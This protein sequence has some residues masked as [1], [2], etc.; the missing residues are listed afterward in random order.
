MTPPSVTAVAPDMAPEEGR[1]VTAKVADR[2]TRHHL[3]LAVT[4]PVRRLGPQGPCRSLRT[5]FAAQFSSE[6]R[7]SVTAQHF[8]LP[9]VSRLVS[10]C[11]V[12]G[13]TVLMLLLLLFA[14]C[15]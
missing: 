6:P 2:P 9:L 4:T 12:G 13:V 3:L 11:H 10:R 1:R 14:E 7:V 8:F 5:R 15:I